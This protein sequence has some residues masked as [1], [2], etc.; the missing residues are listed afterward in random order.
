VACF[1]CVLL[2]ISVARSPDDWH[3]G[4]AKGPF[5]QGRQLVC[6]GHYEQAIPLLQAYLRR[7]PNGRNAS[8]ARFFI[9]KAR[10]GQG[11]LDTAAEQLNLVI[12]SYPES[13]EAHKSHYKL[14]LIAML[15]S[16]ADQAQQ[17]FT[18]IAA[19]ANGP[20]TPE[21]TALKRH[22]T[23]PPPRVP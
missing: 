21:A 7:F 5:G 3:P 1:I 22:L 4:S 18:T 10:L 8:R 13:L 12:Q 23:P 16:N 2:A 14:A 9:A 11:D 17:A 15:K 6:E 19:A 20:L